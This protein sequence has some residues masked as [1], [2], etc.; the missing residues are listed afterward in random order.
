[1]SKTQH[2]QQKGNVASRRHCVSS[3]Q[4]SG[5]LAN[6]NPVWIASVQP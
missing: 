5:E 2:Q 4:I 1:M 6:G 3:F